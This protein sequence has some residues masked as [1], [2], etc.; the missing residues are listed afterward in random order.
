ME[1]V[2]PNIGLI[3]WQTV[4]FLIVF[5]ILATFVWRPIVDAL[6]AREGFISDSLEAA[7]NSKKE[8]AQLKE[9]NEYLLQEARIERDNMLADATKVANQIKE[10]ARTETSKISD[11]MIA[12]AKAA[13]GTEKKAAL[14]DVKNMVASLSLDIA[15]KVLRKNLEDKKAQEG[16][17]QDLI[18]D[19]KVN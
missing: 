5:G 7:E 4:V 9:D 1:L 16:L 19:I 14:A 8:M 11:K 15:E 2:T 12:D 13:I 18:K 6:R 17:V 10:D 3:I